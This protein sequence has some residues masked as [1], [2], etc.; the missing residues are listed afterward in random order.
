MKATLT[1]REK[2]LSIVVGSVAFLFVNYLVVDVFKKN[3]AAL[4]LGI[5]RQT[6][7]LKLTRARSSEKALWQQREAWL[8]EQLPKLTN[9]D[10]ASVQ[11]LDEVKKLAAMHSVTIENPQIRPATRRPEATVVSL[12]IEVRS[13]WKSLVGFLGDLQKPGLFVVLEKTSL[14]VDAKDQTQMAGKF[15]VAKWYA[16]K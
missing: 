8:G 13:P 2:V 10:S 3:K 7:Q 15:T 6:S 16:P 4:T 14:K 12:E 5:A 1:Q 9:E 11:L